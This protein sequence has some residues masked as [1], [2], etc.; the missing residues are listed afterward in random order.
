MRWLCATMVVLIYLVVV[1]DNYRHDGVE[2]N[3]NTC[4]AAAPKPIGPEMALACV[5]AAHGVRK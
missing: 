1:A 5:E 2:R 4:I 3:F